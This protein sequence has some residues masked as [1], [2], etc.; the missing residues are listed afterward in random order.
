MNHAVEWQ[1]ARTL[2]EQWHAT[3]KTV[4]FTNGCFDLL[5]PGHIDYLNKAR[6]LGDALIVGLNDDDS[7]TRLKGPTRPINPLAD[8][9]VMLAA[10]KAVDLVVP[11]EEDTPLEL[12]RLLLPDM[13]V[14]GGDYQPDEIVGAREVRENGGHVTVIDFVDGHSTTALIRR[15]QQVG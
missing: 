10:L 13:L 3:G 7:I 4:V 15:I 11:F 8:R 1:A 6:A 9:Q 5:H 2:V 12:I 14:K